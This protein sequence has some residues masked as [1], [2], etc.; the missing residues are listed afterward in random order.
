MIKV[1]GQ[2]GEDVCD[3]VQARALLDFESRTIVVDGRKIA[4]YNA[5]VR[6]VSQEKYKD[7]AS[8]EVVLLPT[9]LGG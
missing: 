9:I 6:L 8:I 3:L 2:V 4:S 7:R 1:F 5:L